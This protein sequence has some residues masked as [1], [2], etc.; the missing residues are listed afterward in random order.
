MGAIFSFAVAPSPPVAPPPEKRHHPSDGRD[1]LTNT[2]GSAAVVTSVLEFTGW[3][4]ILALETLSWGCR[5][6]VRD[7]PISFRVATDAPMTREFRRMVILA[8]RGAEQI[9]GDMTYRAGYA[10]VPT[11]RKPAAP[12]RAEPGVDVARSVAARAAVERQHAALVNSGVVR[13]NISSPVGDAV[14]ARGLRAL[15]SDRIGFM[16]DPE[17]DKP[18]DPA[19]AEVLIEALG[20]LAERAPLIDAARRKLLPY[21]VGGYVKMRTLDAALARS[22]AA[23][24]SV[25]LSTLRRLVA[26]FAWRTYLE[27]R[28]KDGVIMSYVDEQQFKVLCREVAAPRADEIWA[29][30]TAGLLL[31]FGLH[32]VSPEDGDFREFGDVRVG[33]IAALELDSALVLACTALAALEQCD[34]DPVAV[35]SADFDARSHVLSQYYECGNRLY[36]SLAI[37]D[38]LALPREGERDGEAG[39]K[40]VEAAIASLLTPD[41]LPA[42]HEGETVAVLQNWHERGPSDGRWSNNSTFVKIK[43]DGVAIISDAGVERDHMICGIQR[44][45]ASGEAP[46]AARLLCEA[47]AAGRNEIVVRLLRGME[48]ASIY[49]VQLDLDEHATALDRAIDNGNSVAAALLAAQHGQNFLPH[50]CNAVRKERHLKKTLSLR[51]QGELLRALGIYDR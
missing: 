39:A 29:E 38:A 32:H 4:A 33:D 37:L 25:D 11:P 48:Y 18:A 6:S 3:D 16:G 10:L 51:L 21:T 24:S 17:N 42:L 5:R 30:A 1:V 23:A 8:N 45:N 49:A 36:V 50:A 20:P 2:A 43:G 9:P 34:G 40:R 28:E 12:V 31:P 15:K 27:K 26:R 47:V 7:A 44:I 35:F 41:R 19:L 13:F 14:A 46:A 22:A